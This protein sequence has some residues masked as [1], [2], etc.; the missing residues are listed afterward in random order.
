MKASPLRTG[1]SILL[2]AIA[3][4][5]LLGFAFQGSRGV[6]ETSEGR[7][8]AVASE[9]LRTGNWMEPS[10]GP[11]EPHWTK[12]P[13]AYWAIA[14]S[15][16]VFG[17]NDFAVRFPGAFAFILSCALVLAVGRVLVPRNPWLPAMIY[18][19]FVFT[20]GASNAV[21][22]D[23]L[24]AM[25]E[26]AAVACFCYVYF[27]EG[28]FWK[29]YG[30]YFGWT[31]LG[32]AFF[33]KGPPAL[34]PLLSILIFHAVIGRKYAVS[35]RWF[36]GS[37]LMLLMGG[38]WYCLMMY[39]H[40]GL[41]A[42]WFHDEVVLRVASSHHDR[43]PQWYGAFRAYLPVLLLGTLPW[44]VPVWRAV[45]RKMH[46]WIRRKR[47]GGKGLDA[48]SVFLMLLIVLPLIIFFLVR[49]RLPLYLLPVF[50]PLSLLGAR[51]MEPESIYR[52]YAVHL[53]VGAVI[54]IVFARALSGYI[55]CKRDSRALA[56]QLQPIIAE[57]SSG[58]LIFVNVKPFRGTSLYLNM[59]VGRV[60]TWANET[61][62]ETLKKRLSDNETDPTVWLVQ[63]KSAK[64]FIN[65]MKKAGAEKNK[66]GRVSCK[67]GEMLVFM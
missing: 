22:T 15:V 67:Y 57:A 54:L 60:W 53:A 19:S 11:G 28:G 13:L 1:K 63:E 3:G 9:M 52:K 6:W 40:P 56:E 4:V 21:T 31:F 30:A 50:V 35:L 27:S 10:L 47:M 33:T 64:T 61:H 58:H 62:P 59:S 5:L 2:L 8:V 20:A 29:H 36:S 24:L 26:T 17:R 48:Q 18:G 12:P 23:P 55:D 65:I 49:S 45:W 38:W 44:T 37:V 39:Q 42:Y 16:L 51:E 14:S 34:I 25:F 41:M 7:Y 32:L 66:C 46:A 43:H